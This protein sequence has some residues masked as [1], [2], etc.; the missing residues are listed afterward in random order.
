MWR[1]HDNLGSALLRAGRLP[2]AIERFQHA[3]RLNPQALD[4]YGHLADAQAKAH[5]PDEAIAT[6]ERALQLAAANGD[7]GTAAKIEAQ[8]AAFRAGLNNP[9]N[10]E[11]IPNFGSAIPSD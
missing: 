7:Q 10:A 8:L 9:T 5:R 3:V 1:A 11:T 4:V 2:E 6:A